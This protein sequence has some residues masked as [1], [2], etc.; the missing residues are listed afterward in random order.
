VSQGQRVLGYPGDYPVYQDQMDKPLIVLVLE[1]SAVSSCFSMGSEMANI[2]G[3]AELIMGGSLKV[4]VVASQYCA[5]TDVERDFR[6]DENVDRG[7]DH[8]M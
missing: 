5:M 7:Q 2:Y 4:S 3:L 6:Y 1:I 8:R